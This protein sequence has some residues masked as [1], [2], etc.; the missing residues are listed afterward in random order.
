MADLITVA[1]KVYGIKLMTKSFFATSAS[2]ALSSVTSREIGWAFLTPS[3]SF[4]ALS[5]VLHAELGQLCL[6]NWTCYLPTD[7]SMPA[8]LRIS[9]VGLVTKPAPSIRT[10]LKTIS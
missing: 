2:R 7:T 3:E 1:W 6:E 9:R 4:L 10:F 8:S 5:R